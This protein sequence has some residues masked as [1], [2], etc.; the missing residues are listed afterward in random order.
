M[1]VNVYT[2]RFIYTVIGLKEPTFWYSVLYILGAANVA[3]RPGAGSV[4]GVSTGQ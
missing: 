3:L 1:F 4:K 2:V